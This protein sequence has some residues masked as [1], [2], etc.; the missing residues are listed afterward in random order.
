MPSSDVPRDRRSMSPPRPDARAVVLGI[1]APPHPQ[2][3]EGSE[4]GSE[5]DSPPRIIF[6]AIQQ[7][8]EPEFPTSPSYSPS[9]PPIPSPPGS[10]PSVDVKPAGT[11]PYDD[12]DCKAHAQQ[13]CILYAESAL[14]HYD[15]DEKNEVKYELISGIAC[16]EMLVENGC[17]GHVNFTAKGNQHN[18]KEELFFA[19]L[20]WD[21]DTPVTTCVVSLEG[22][23]H[24]GGL[25]D[26]KYDIFL[27]GCSA[28]RC[29]E[30]LCLR[31]SN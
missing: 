1:H 15:N 12:I 9:G 3:H 19:E 27:S 5:L 10:P 29:K 7:D 6:V 11:E 30:L 25:R 13:K 20:R 17:Y 22:E 24:T 31:S 4:S 28:L 8:E 16:S 18:S 14:K 21:G 2:H 26:S 23:K